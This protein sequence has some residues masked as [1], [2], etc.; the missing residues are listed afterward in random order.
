[1][2]ERNIIPQVKR[3][4]ILLIFVL[5]S[6]FLFMQSDKKIMAQQE[7]GLATTESQVGALETPLINRI[8]A[9]VA[10]ISVTL[11]LTG[12]DGK[13]IEG[14]SFVIQRLKANDTW[15]TFNNEEPFITDSLGEIKMT[16]ELVAVM[17]QYGGKENDRAYRF[18]EISVPKGSGYIDPPA[19]SG[20]DN[21]KTASNGQTL[22]GFV[23]ANMDITS[24]STVDYQMNLSLDKSVTL[25]LTGAD[26]KP[27]EGASFVIQRLRVT[28]KWTTFNG[29]KPFITDSLGEIKMT[30]ELVAV[31]K[32]YGGRDDNKAFRFRE[33]SVPKDSGYVVPPPYSGTDDERAASNGQ[34]LS[35]FI[36]DRMDITSATTIDYQV[37][38]SHNKMGSSNLVNNPLFYR[39][40]N[41]NY[42]PGWVSFVGSLG[43]S[44]GATPVL[45][46]YT[47]PMAVLPWN[48]FEEIPLAEKN[49]INEWLYK[50]LNVTYPDINQL[51][52][53][54][55][56]TKNYLGELEVYQYDPANSE[57]YVRAN[58]TNAT[59]KTKQ[60]VFI[61][62][63]TI[64]V[65]PNTTYRF[66]LSYHLP[67]GLADKAGTVEILFYNGKRVT[68]PKEG[69]N[70]TELT[71]GN[72]HDLY[73][74]FKTSS[75]A[76]EVSLSLRINF[77]VEKVSWASVKNVWLE[78]GSGDQ[79]EG[80]GEGEAKE[81]TVNY[82]QDG[83][84]K[85][86]A[87]IPAGNLGRSW[88]APLKTYADFDFD[89]AKLDGVNVSASAEKPVTGIFKST[90]QTVDYYFKK[91]HD[92]KLVADPTDWGK[93]FVGTQAPASSLFNGKVH[94]YDGDTKVETLTSNFTSSIKAYDNS[95]AGAKKFDVTFQSTAQ[96][97]A[98]YPGLENKSTVVATLDV[99]FYTE[100]KATSV[101]QTYFEKVD[102][103][104]AEEL[105]SWV[106]D[107]TVNGKAAGDNYTVDLVTAW[108]S[109]QVIAKEYQVKVSSGGL[110]ETIVVTVTYT[111]IGDL[112]LDV[113]TTL[114][115][116]DVYVRKGKE[117]VI[118]RKNDNWSLSV[119]DQR[120]VVYQK[121]WDL[122][123]KLE[124]GLTLEKDDTKVALDDVL[125]YK[126]DSSSVPEVLKIGERHEILNHA[127]GVSGETKM[128]WSPDAGFLLKIDRLKSRYIEEG[129]Y[130]A[131]LEF[132][133]ADTP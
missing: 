99:L 20:T 11:K 53:D 66:G 48:R 29:E 73:T 133:L 58:T 100:L 17:K 96:L 8:E 37:R 84:I 119:D 54:P 76:D 74:E 122:S 59:N 129:A 126:K 128:S 62:G 19:Y 55:P 92:Y 28:G 22:I 81:V 40:A 33:I 75:T 112:I 70:T 88:S 63:Q 9:K 2:K 110:S 93:Q 45:L 1:M 4:I 49:D 87:S 131:V 105:K 130:K 83:V 94:V 91:K 32:Q 10:D 79:G 85:E 65:K 26:G 68:G 77:P 118:H 90:Q 95:L 44:L 111:P 43:F 18:R 14:A 86:T 21:E 78:E 116:R 35:G 69:F 113:P 61:L 80:S 3:Y 7:E 108:D 106:K 127:T 121:G 97:N 71:D 51:N 47:H 107:V 27:I 16:P 34:T 38:M 12:A 42:V 60:F 15:T 5:V 23:S 24:A 124:E 82:H 117:Q 41:T 72:W 114:N 30:P 115:F 39:N 36:A 13:P 102:V 103:P 123:V 109:S 56:P 104:T 67:A 31:M 125:I 57:L 64:P 25:K 98:K 132:T 46:N 89:S 52:I 120:H 101:A 50:G 6:G